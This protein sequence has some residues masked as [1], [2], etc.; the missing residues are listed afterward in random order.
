MKIDSSLL[1]DYAILT[2]KGE[3]DTFYCPVLQQE[4]EGLV[5]RGIHHVVLDLRL[6]KFINSTALGAIIKAHKRLRAEGGELVLSQPSSFVRDVV[7][8]VGIDAVVP[9]FETEAEATKAIVKHLNQRELAGDFQ[10][11]QA[12]VLISF[13]DQTRQKMLGGRKALVGS[14]ANVDGSRVIFTYSG[15][16]SGITP[17]QSKQLFFEGGD[18]RLKFQVKMIKKGFF[19]IGARVL[20][21]SEHG[22]SVRVEAS[23]ERASDADRAALQQFAEDMAFLKHH[24]PGS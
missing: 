6:V 15:K 10:V 5:E 1:D 8:K 17:D 18:L 4:V 19:E 13:E 12:T 22:D 24:L 3:F 7:K 21:A 9:M 16:R 23:I 14:M 2:L 20:S 11:D